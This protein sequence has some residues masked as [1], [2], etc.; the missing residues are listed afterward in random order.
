MSTRTRSY[1]VQIAAV[2]GY[3]MDSYI[4]KHFSLDTA[5]DLRLV[6]V[7]TVESSQY[8]VDTRE[9]TAVYSLQTCCVQI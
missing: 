7:S 2:H 9:Y 1:S 3:C 5:T 6:G 4:L 8:T